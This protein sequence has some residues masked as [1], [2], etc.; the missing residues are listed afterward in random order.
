MNI[1]AVKPSIALF[2][3]GALALMPV[4]G[5][6]FPRFYAIGP[7]FIGIAGLLAL[8]IK[9]RTWPAIPKAFWIIPLCLLTLSS[10]SFF[11]SIAPNSSL[12][13]CI[14]LLVI[15]GTG[16][17]LLC[18]L[19]EFKPAQIKPAIPL[20]LFGLFTA[21]LFIMF[22]INFGSMLYILSR[23][24]EDANPAFG[25]AIYNRATVAV[26]LCLFPCI[27][28]AQ[29]IAPDRMVQL[30]FFAIVLIMLLSSQSQ[31][32]QFGLIIGALIYWLF[33]YGRP[34]AWYALMAII[35]L[36]ILSAP[37][38]AMY[39]YDNYAST[40][41]EAPFFRAGSGYAGGR[42]EI[43]DMV[44]RKALENPLLGH[45][46]EATKTIR[47]FDT[48]MM[49]HQAP[50]VLHPHNF[51]IQFWIEFGALGAVVISGL[52][53][54]LLWLI[55]SLNITAQRIALPTFMAA[56]AIAAVAYG[57]WQ[58]W[59]IGLLFMVTGLCILVVKLT[60]EA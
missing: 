35:S 47:D 42:T 22:E 52:I 33:P 50:H 10:L 7:G 16:P 55:K 37:Y 31:S 19:R 40:L 24:I 60:E 29:H 49:Y 56:L 5:V 14:K 44:S 43:W 17:L 2:V 39:L 45:G 38:L 36:L 15:L 1:K 3:I 51:A 48:Q 21:A 54:Y 46:I 23:G 58:S 41:N 9:Q 4:I 18:A 12:E 13:R 28:I 34:K 59:W 32:A 20:I 27:A 53:S 57:F 25:T 30:G 26:V 6:L 11:W 8:Y